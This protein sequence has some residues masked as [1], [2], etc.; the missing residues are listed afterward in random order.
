M[1]TDDIPPEVALCLRCGYFMLEHVPWNKGSGTYEITGWGERWMPTH[2]IEPFSESEYVAGS[3]S[4]L[5]WN[6]VW[7]RAED[8]LNCFH[9]DDPYTYFDYIYFG[10]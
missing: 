9:E 8:D 6:E 5:L 1:S 4:R 7:E 10:M 3:P 2:R